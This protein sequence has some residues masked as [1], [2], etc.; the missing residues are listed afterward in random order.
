[1]VLAITGLTDL[2]AIP[3]VDIEDLLEIKNK[4]KNFVESKVTCGVAFAQT[5]HNVSETTTVALV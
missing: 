1:M 5:L 3:R 4:K 2:S